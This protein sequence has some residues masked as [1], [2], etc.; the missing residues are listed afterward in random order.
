MDS[1]KNIPTCIFSTFSIIE[2]HIFITRSLLDLTS[3]RYFNFWL[4]V[5]VLWL[6][7][8]RESKAETFIFDSQFCTNNARQ[9]CLWPRWKVAHLNFDHGFVWS[10]HMSGNHCHLIS[11]SNRI[12]ILF[13]SFLSLLND[14]F[15]REKLIRLIQVNKINNDFWERKL[16]INREVEDSF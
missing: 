9:S 12:I 16:S 13:F 6:E 10:C 2:F 3:F 7:A 14:C 5:H 1:R 11:L 8:N 4:M 15:N